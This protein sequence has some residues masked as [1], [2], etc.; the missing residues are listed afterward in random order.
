[1]SKKRFNDPFTLIFNRVI[2]YHPEHVEFIYPEN[3]INII[4]L[5]KKIFLIKYCLKKSIQRS[6][7]TSQ[8][9]IATLR[10]L[11]SKRKGNFQCSGWIDCEQLQLCHNWYT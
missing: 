4:N 7:K 10:S 8:Q 9:T 1:M 5:N 11:Q 3:Q 2:N 6:S